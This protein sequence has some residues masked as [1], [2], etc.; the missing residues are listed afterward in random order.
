[1]NLLKLGGL[2]GLVY[3]G[4]KVIARQGRSA[5][6]QRLASAV[7]ALAGSVAGAG[8]G[9]GNPGERLNAARLSAV[10]SGAGLAGCS[11]QS[12]PGPSATGLADFNRGA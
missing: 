7:P 11:A 12:G 9:S 6:S 1:M 4:R 10:P 2:I 5:W 3:F 8:S